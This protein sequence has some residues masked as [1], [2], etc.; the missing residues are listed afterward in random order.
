MKFTTNNKLAILSVSVVGIIFLIYFQPFS[1]NLDLLESEGDINNADAEIINMIENR[2]S[3]SVTIEGVR[4]LEKETRK[5]I[6]TQTD[7]EKKVTDNK[8][9]KND[10]EDDR[11]EA[12]I[13]T[14]TPEYIEVV[15]GCGPYYDG[16]CLRVRR[17]PSTNSKTAT[18]LRNGQVLEVEKIVETRGRIWYKVV[19]DEWMRYPERIKGDWYVAGEFVRPLQA[20]EGDWEGEDPPEDEAQKRIVVDL[21]EQVLYA[22]N[23]ENIFLETPVSTGLTAGLTP[24]GEF[25][26]FYKTPSRYMQGPIPGITDDEYDL[27]GVP[28]N[29]YFTRQGAVIHGAYWHDNFGMNWSHGCVNLPPRVAEKLYRWAPEGTK[30]VVED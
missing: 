10:R 3:S 11:R 7:D 17:Q 12:V 24:R 4:E 14:T 23:G 16:E 20:Q 1:G 15:D 26:V 13:S 8:K 9:S 6:E 27:P 28:W 22:Y 19:F 5:K 30:V 2:S 18:V 21:S 29:L 25:S